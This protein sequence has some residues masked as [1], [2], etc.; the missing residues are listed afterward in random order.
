M[1]LVDYA[2][3]QGDAY[4][5]AVHRKFFADR[6]LV[7]AWAAFF[8]HV[9]FRELPQGVTVLEIGAGLGINLLSIK[10]VAEVYAV[11]PAEIAR[12]HCA[13][14][15][16][17]VVAALSELPEGLRFDHVMLCHV[18]EHLPEPRTML[19]AMRPLL[20][21]SG[22]LLVVVPGESPWAAPDPHDANHHLYGWSRQTMANLLVDSGYR[23]VS[24]TL[25]WC[26]GRRVFLPIYRRWG[27]RPYAQALHL[28]GR[29][30]R[31]GEVVIVAQT[32]TDG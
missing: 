21:E 19:L 13:S 14:L 17:R 32:A 25:N 10:S 31:D 22:R 1:P 26:S 8:H 24:A 11:E 6:V 12:A 15:G 4:H 3:S 27:V 18:L 30:R 29:L 16:I 7:E 20:K 28:F 2:S 5:E 9:H 23:V